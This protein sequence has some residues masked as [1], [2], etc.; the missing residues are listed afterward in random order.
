MGPPSPGRRWALSRRPGLRL[1]GHVL[2]GE[3]PKSF[4]FPPGVSA[5]SS[6]ATGRGTSLVDAHSS[7]RILT[8]GLR[9][10]DAL[11]SLN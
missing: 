3:A 9:F 4:D 8:V 2:L 5:R 11:S 1:Q 10:C 7:A 6:V